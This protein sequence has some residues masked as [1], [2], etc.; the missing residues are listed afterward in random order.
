MPLSLSMI[1]LSIGF[2]LPN[3]KKGR[4]IM[5]ISIL[6]LYLF[7]NQF[8]SN[9]ALQIWEPAFIPMEEVPIHDIG[10]VMYRIAGYM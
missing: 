4:K 8:I 2:F 3:R 5:G 10:I 9:W 1:G 6:L 7:S